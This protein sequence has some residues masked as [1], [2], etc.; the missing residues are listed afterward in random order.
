MKIKD[1]LKNHRLITD[2]AMGT[3]YDSIKEK[4]ITVE[5]ANYE[6]PELIK[7]IYKEYIAA[8]SRLLRTNTFDIKSIMDD[9][10]YTV[11]NYIHQ[12]CRIAEEAVK[13]SR[14]ESIITKEEPVFIGADIGPIEFDETK[15][16]EET[17][18]DYKK[19][20]DAFLQEKIDT[21]IFETQTDVD[22]VEE[23]TAY[24]KSKSDV[25][26]LVQFCFDKS[27]YTKTGL[28][29]K[30]MIAQMETKQSVD[31]YGFNCGMSSSHLYNAI[32]DLSFSGNKV[33]S[34]LPNA[35]Y[36]NIV[37]G[38][39][40]YSNNIPYYADKMDKIDDLGVRILGGCCGTTPLYI[41]KL[42]EKL[43][44][45]KLS[46]L[47]VKA[48]NHGEEEI[49]Q[50]QNPMIEK[51]NHGEKVIM[52]E[53]D[54]PFDDNI[55]KV[56]EGAYYL[57]G[58]GCD[59]ITI[60]D[61]PLGR[62]RMEAAML[63]AKIQRETG[64]PVMPHISCR[65]RNTI[66]LRGMFL[67]LNMEGIRNMLIV[68][69]DP[70][71][72]TDHMKQ[73]FEYNSIRLM[74]YVDKMNEEVFDGHRFVY[75]GALN[76]NGVNKEA[77]AG[78]MKDKMKAGASFFLTQP[79]YSDED[80]KRIAYL[81]QET[82]AKIMAGIMPLVSHRNATFIKNEMPGIFVPDEIIDRYQDGLTREE[83]EEIAVE[84]SVDVIRKLGNL[85]DGYYFMTP[86]NRY[87]LI[88]RIINA[89]ED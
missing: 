84:I 29:V 37:R 75:G 70:V 12:T 15:S 64:I 53:L 10:Q 66:S 54:P 49:V 51:L 56:M 83:Y 32:K 48:S 77:I 78:R 45:K 34:A 24:I 76:Y 8:G 28:S 65:D 89:I 30:S 14:E 81:K 55:D 22:F 82:G 58:K 17:M 5:K 86:F 18:E 74:H 62:T 80:I 20:C 67:G 1:Y 25:Y 6:N 79:I 40:V 3:Y 9:A 4:D 85:A 69:G 26:V 11:E 73:V 27:G 7:A 88:Q 52:V 47:R 44:N 13:E 43:Q 87:K 71:Q 36:S 38:K 2:G 41:Q 23:L 50:E 68:T 31:A 16:Q 61:S 63:S 57:K 60:S 21:F 72:K 35:S 19:V 33:I 46:K 42:S 59:V 39:L